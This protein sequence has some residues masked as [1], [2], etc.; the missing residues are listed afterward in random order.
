MRDEAVKTIERIGVDEVVEGPAHLLLELNPTMVDL[1]TS[2]KG[3]TV[4]PHEGDA[5]PDQEGAVPK[6]RVSTQQVLSFSSTTFQFAME[7]HFPKVQLVVRDAL[8]KLTD[9][10]RKMFVIKSNL[11]SSSFY[12]YSKFFQDNV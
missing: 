12:I 8:E 7:P 5:L 4:I 2:P 3:K 11:W 9:C 6:M 1:A 10:W